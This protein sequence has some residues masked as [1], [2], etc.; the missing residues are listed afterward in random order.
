MPEQQQRNIISAVERSSCKQYIVHAL[1]RPGT[2]VGDRGG[3]QCHRRLCTLFYSGHGGKLA[4]LGSSIITGFSCTRMQEKL[5]S[6]I[7]FHSSSRTEN[8]GGRK[9]S[10]C[11]S[12]SFTRTAGGGERESGTCTPF[13]RT[14]LVDG[15]G[16]KFL[17]C[18]SFVPTAVGRDGRKSPTRTPFV[19]TAVDGGESKPSTW[20]PFV[21]TVANGGGKN[22]KKQQ[23]ILEG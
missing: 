22:Q 18:T 14:L 16:R 6:F 1:D 20:T 10:T 15:S 3:N 19:S 23:H 9:S 13:V 8:G 5:F 7:T 11:T 12:F 17:T 21:S 2:A 4:L